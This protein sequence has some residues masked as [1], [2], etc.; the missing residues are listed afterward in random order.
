MR[1]GGS[2]AARA[3]TAAAL[4]V[5]V[6]V[7]AIVLFGTGEGDYRVTGTFENAAQI[8]KGNPV[9]SGGV[10]IG[11]VKDVALAEED[12]GR[13]GHRQH[14]DGQDDRSNNPRWNSPH[15]PPQRASLV[16]PGGGVNGQ[17]SP[18]RRCCAGR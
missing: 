4:V 1:R 5:A 16:T 14:D 8:V 11:S 12:D 6:A 3:A 7:T 13:S 9:Q 18:R 15:R 17:P 10:T 2:S